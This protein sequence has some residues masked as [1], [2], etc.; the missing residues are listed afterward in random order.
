V[1]TDVGT[2]SFG[3]VGVKKHLGHV[4]QKSNKQPQISDRV[5]VI[6]ISF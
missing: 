6:L 3:S 2:K 5:T 1:F 4:Q